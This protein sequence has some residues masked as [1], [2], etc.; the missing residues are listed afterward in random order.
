MDY[1]PNDQRV[2]SRQVLAGWILC[3]A[4][5]GLAFAATGHRQAIPSVDAGVSP[6]TVIAA[7]CPVSGARLPS[8]I[9]CAEQRG[10]VRMARGPLSLPIYPCG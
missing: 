9:S 8:F 4:M 10:A 2:T 6:R 7:C 3:L 5:V 1:D